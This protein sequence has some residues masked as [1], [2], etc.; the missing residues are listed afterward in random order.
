MNQCQMLGKGDQRTSWAQLGGKDFIG[1]A[2]PKLDLKEEAT[3]G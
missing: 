1:Q 2:E 3:C